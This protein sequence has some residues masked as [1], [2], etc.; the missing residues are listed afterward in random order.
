VPQHAFKKH[1]MMLG[2]VTLLLCIG[3]ISFDTSGVTT[4]DPFSMTQF[5]NS[6]DM[7]IKSINNT[8]GSTL[9]PTTLESKLSKL[10]TWNQEY[11]NLKLG[12]KYLGIGIYCVYFLYVCLIANWR[13][14]LRDKIKEF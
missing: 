13:Y 11:H 14:L 12:V 10:I 2:I 4:T 7:A 1:V 5:H 9:D 3:F 6:L 8:D